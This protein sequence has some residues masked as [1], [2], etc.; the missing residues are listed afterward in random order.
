MPKLLIALGK[1][2]VL[3]KVLEK[4]RQYAIDYP[5]LL[6]KDAAKEFSQYNDLKKDFFKNSP[7]LNVHFINYLAK[8]DNFT[9]FDNLRYIDTL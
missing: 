8:N 4:F 5:T 1:R 9:L 2:R 6:Q 7:A 3:P